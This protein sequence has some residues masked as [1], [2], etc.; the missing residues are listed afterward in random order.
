MCVCVCVHIYTFMSMLIYIHL[1]IYTCERPHARQLREDGAPQQ[2]ALLDVGVL[3][4]VR[5]AE[6]RAAAA[7]RDGETRS[8]VRRPAVK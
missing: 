2:Q 4:P 3:R 8:L 6:P 1:Y 5:V 7:R